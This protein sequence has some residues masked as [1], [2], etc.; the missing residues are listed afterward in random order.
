MRNKKTRVRGAGRRV[1]G[2]GCKGKRNPGPEERGS[3]N[4][5]WRRGRENRAE[6]GMKTVQPFGP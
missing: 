1:Q 6:C 4:M 3:R 5:G 2:V